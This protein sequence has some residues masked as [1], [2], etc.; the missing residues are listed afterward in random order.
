MQDRILEIVVYLM[1]QLA[2]EQ[3]SLNSIDDMSDDL[4]SMGFTD[5]EISSAYSWL[6][7]HFE[8]YPES[9]E[10]RDKNK[11]RNSF[12]VLSDIERKIISPEGYGYLI[13]LKKLGLLTT[14][15]F[16]MILDRCA[17]FTTDPVSVGEIK[18]FASAAMFDT[19]STD[20]PIPVWIDDP[21]NEPVN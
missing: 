4:R 12:R 8:D 14:E 15:Q 5:K 21:E 6:L 19:G 3:G 17:L 7:N 18:M 10:F 1:N 11:K 16:E 13:Q 2:E 20:L 9:F